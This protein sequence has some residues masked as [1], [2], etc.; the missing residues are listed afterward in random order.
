MLCII[1]AAVFELAI[2]YV[3]ERFT[4]C[5]ANGD[6]I[7]KEF[8]GLIFLHAQLGFSCVLTT[9]PFDPQLLLVITGCR[10]LFPI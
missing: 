9:P 3:A 5:S 6:S 10:Q 1:V 8:A 4:E 7:R 2:I